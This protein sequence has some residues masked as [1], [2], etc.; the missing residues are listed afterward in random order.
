MAKSLFTTPKKVKASQVLVTSVETGGGIGTV[1][2][3]SKEGA[4]QA[5]WG[6]G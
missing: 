5:L 4:R 3:P 2:S 6:R 1:G